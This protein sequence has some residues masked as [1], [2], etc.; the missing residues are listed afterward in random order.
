MPISWH[1]HHEIRNHP[2]LYTIYFWAV[3]WN[4]AK[5]NQHDPNGSVRFF[6]WIYQYTVYLIILIYFI[7]WDFRSVYLKCLRPS[8]QSPVHTRFEYNIPNKQNLNHIWCIIS[9]LQGVFSK[10]WWD[11]HQDIEITPPHAAWAYNTSL[12]Y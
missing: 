4:N 9:I 12:C 10:I 3:T 1:L 11:K 6:L 2:V 5:V 8:K 7:P